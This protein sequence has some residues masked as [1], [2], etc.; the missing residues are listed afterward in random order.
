MLRLKGL[1]AVEGVPV[2]GA[3][4]GDTTT[5]AMPIARRVAGL[6]AFRRS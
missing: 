1:F 5:G 2:G 3:F 6:L 4:D